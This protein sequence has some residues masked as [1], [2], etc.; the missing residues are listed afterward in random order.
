MT[1]NEPEL[2]YPIEIN[3]IGRKK[4]FKI[5]ADE[6]EC[7]KLAER[8]QIIS[9]ENLHALVTVEPIKKKISYCVEGS[10]EADVAQL[11]VITL[12]PVKQ[13]IKET[14]K[15]TF[16][17]DAETFDENAPI[18]ENFFEEDDIEPIFD[19]IIDIGEEVAEQLS[20]VLDPFPKK[21]EATFKYN[22]GNDENTAQNH[23]KKNPFAVLAT[24]KPKK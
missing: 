15:T 16:S 3:R 23:G 18:P 7:S 19:G 22:D 24:L 6:N 4:Q 10:F 20:M 1:N 17:I 2:H 5:N 12:E 13:H 21:Q 9:I 8:F 11:C 14:F